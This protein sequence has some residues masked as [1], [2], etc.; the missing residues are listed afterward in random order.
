MFHDFFYEIVILK[1]SAKKYCQNKNE[2]WT[3]RGRLVWTLD[4]NKGSR[5]VFVKLSL[6]IFC[7]KNRQNERSSALFN[8]ISRIIFKIWPEWNYEIA[9]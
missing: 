3:N 5:I 7:E 4:V 2:V 8:K 9:I 6:R 1:F